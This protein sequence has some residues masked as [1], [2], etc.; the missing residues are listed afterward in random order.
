MVNHIKIIRV[1]IVLFAFSIFGM[2]LNGE[3][4]PAENNAE[5]KSDTN[6]AERVMTVI[7][8]KGR[9]FIKAGKNRYILS[10]GLKITDINGNYVTYYNMPVPV[11]A[12][13][14]L[15]ITQ[16]SDPYVLEIV[17]QKEINTYIPE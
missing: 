6:S 8:K 4:V 3:T 17:I 12:M 16:N 9:G 2:G 10:E 7:N 15:R 14:L 1:L 13:L 5:F 11:N